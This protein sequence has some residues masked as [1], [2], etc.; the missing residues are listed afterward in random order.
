MPDDKTEVSLIIHHCFTALAR[1]MATLHCYA[2]AIS[3]IVLRTTNF[4]NPE[5]SEQ[6]LNFHLPDICTFGVCPPLRSAQS[7]RSDDKTEV[8]LITT[9][10]TNWSYL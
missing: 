10:T 3:G 9:L 5:I 2:S 4:K 6:A 8:S 1:L 7:Q